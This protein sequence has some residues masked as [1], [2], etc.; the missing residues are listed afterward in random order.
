MTSR[1]APG[2]SRE[3]SER[4]PERPGSAPEAPRISFGRPEGPRERFGMIFGGF[5]EDFHSMFGRFS[6]RLRAPSNDPLC[7][8][9][10]NVPVLFF[11][12]FLC[13]VPL[14]RLYPL[15]SYFL[16]VLLSCYFLLV[17]LHEDSL[18]YIYILDLRHEASL[19]SERGRQRRS[20]LHR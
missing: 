17:H 9:L 20:R 6:L 5:F 1:G 3:L 7:V 18:V 19:Q 13:L 11:G 10:G 8:L 4:L 14:G 2:A 16:L 12:I 15:P